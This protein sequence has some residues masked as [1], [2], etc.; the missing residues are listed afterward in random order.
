M[1][2][3]YFGKYGV[4]AIMI[5]RACVGQPWVFK[6]IR[7]YLDTGELLPQP[8]L[9]EKVETAKEQLRLFIEDK[10]DWRGIIAMRRHFVHFFKGLKDFRETRTRLLRSN[11]AEENFRILD[12]I[13]ERF[14][15]LPYNPSSQI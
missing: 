2:K 3:E 10:G 11:D 12:E 14:A 4:D 7:H 8:S 15:G 13:G 1:A 5:G 6:H 9:A